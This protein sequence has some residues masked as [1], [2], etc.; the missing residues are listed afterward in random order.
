MLKIPESMYSKGAKNNPT[1]GKSWETSG[2][3]AYGDAQL[4]M[5]NPPPEPVTMGMLTIKVERKK[6]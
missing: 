1:P 4:R 2:S 5:L 3:R 6:K